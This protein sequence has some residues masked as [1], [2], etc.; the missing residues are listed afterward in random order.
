VDYDTWKTTDPSFE[1]E[2]TCY[3]CDEY[4]SEKYKIGDKFYC[5]YC[6]DRHDPR[7]D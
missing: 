4:C 6:F 2:E 1:F 3:D 7:L 5:Q